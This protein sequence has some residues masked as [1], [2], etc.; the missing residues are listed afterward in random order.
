M[1]AVLHF[2]LPEEDAE[3]YNAVHAGKAF[4]L[5]HWIDNEIRSRLKYGKGEISDEEFLLELRRGIREEFPD[6]DER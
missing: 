4:S 1:R 2:S 3:Y 5:L 6:I